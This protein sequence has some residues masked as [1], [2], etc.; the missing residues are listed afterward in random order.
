[1]AGI[2][3]GGGL[4]AACARYGGE[5]KDWLDLSTG[6]NPN[7]VAL[8]EIPE[9]VWNRLP[10]KALE[11]AAREAARDWYLSA[12]GSPPSVLPD[13]SPSRG[14]IDQ[15]QA[16]HSEANVE[17]IADLG[18]IG[19]SG[20]PLLISPLEGEMPGR[21]EGGDAEQN[22]VSGN[23]PLPVPGTQSFI[24]IL[25]KLIPADRPVA[26]LSPTYGEYA[27]CFRRAGMTVDAIG[28]LD[29]LTGDHGALVIVNPNNPTGGT[30]LRRELT[31]LAARMRK[32]GGHLHIDEA[33][34]DA[35]P[36]LSLAALAGETGGVTVSRS[37][38]KFFGL[39]GLR[40]GFVF[41]VP[42]AL[43]TIEAELGPWAV[44]GP[45][46][47]LANELMRGDRKRIL[48]D[49]QARQAALASV[50]HAAELE[51]VGGTELFALVR[52]NRAQDLFEHLARLHILVRKF[53]YAGDWLRIGLAPDEQGD[54][55]LA[56]ALASIR[57]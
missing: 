49:I 52:H 42:E 24:Q 23:L 54:R 13:I 43:E 16:H 40:L 35:R 14:E 41:A 29:E 48:S 22:H 18:W 6:I 8:P 21:A 51:T 38:G 25:P 33:F 32:Q 37:F 50:L 4:T 26:I 30:F 44:S 47:Y 15:T 57:D 27:H 53:D 5:P 7:M 2:T 19:A 46:L 56:Q 28:S 11:R 55:R 1:M 39:A 45:A 3:H 34:G 12:A 36:E 31:G 10:D 9:A 17:N 20:A